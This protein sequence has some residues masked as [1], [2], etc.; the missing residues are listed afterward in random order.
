MSTENKPLLSDG[1][2]RRIEWEA[3]MMQGTKAQMMLVLKG[4]MDERDELKADRAKTRAVVQRLVDAAN[5]NLFPNTL[6]ADEVALMAMNNAGSEKS[7]NTAREIA[8]DYR[9]SHDKLHAA[10]SFA[11][12]ELGIEPTPEKP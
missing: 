4:V 11:K 9:R 12:T 2:L 1:A 5:A 8:N 10:L 3:Y 7:I 6:S